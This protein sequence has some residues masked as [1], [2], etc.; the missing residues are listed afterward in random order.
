VADIEE[1]DLYHREGDPPRDDQ[2]AIR[3]LLRAS[4]LVPILW[5]LASLAL[6]WWLG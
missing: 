4:V 2:S 6:L 3:L 5:F 1:R